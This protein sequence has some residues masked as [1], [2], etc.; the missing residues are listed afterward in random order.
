ME[1]SSKCIAGNVGDL[2]KKQLRKREK[3][4]YN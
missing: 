3:K 2:M 1:N 4:E